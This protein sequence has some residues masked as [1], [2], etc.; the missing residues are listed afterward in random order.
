[1]NIIS[2]VLNSLLNY[3]FNITGDLGVAIILLTLL[4]RALLMPLSIKQKLSMK[5][6]QR[7]GKDLEEIKQKYKNNKEKLEAETQKYYAENAKG[8]FGCLTTLIQF[9]V[10]ITLYNVILKMPMQV[11]TMLVPWVANLKMSDSYFIVPAMYVLSMFMPNLLSYIP[12]LKVSS[13]VKVSKANMVVTGIMSA[14]ITFKAPVA[15]GLYFI[16]TS[17]FSFIEEIVFRVY[18]RKTSFNY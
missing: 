11:G 2:S 17:L 12:F 5:E 18:V 16:T 7:I 4:V 3:L 6:Q 1:M 10:V 15:L 8:M 13:Q 9:P 14:L